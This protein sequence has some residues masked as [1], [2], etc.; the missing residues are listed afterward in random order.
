MPTLLYEANLEP[1]TLNDTGLDY[2][3]YDILCVVNNDLEEFQVLPWGF[4][5]YMSSDRPAASQ[6]ILFSDHKL[7]LKSTAFRDSTDWIP[8]GRL[9]LWISPSYPY[10][11]CSVAIWSPF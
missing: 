3:R 5:D 1:D 2:Q 6:R 7:V 10:T 4:L 8:G 9:W 11:Q